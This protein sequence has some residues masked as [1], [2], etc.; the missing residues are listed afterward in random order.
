MVWK[1]WFQENLC[2]KSP[3]GLKKRD[4]SAIVRTEQSEYF[5]PI[6]FYVQNRYEGNN[7][8]D[9]TNKNGEHV[10]LFVLVIKIRTKRLIS[11]KF[12]SVITTLFKLLCRNF[13]V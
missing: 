11:R 4:Q 2:V 13:R 9:Q 10:P 12:V 3:N 6:Y 7:F 5:L 1:V 8:P